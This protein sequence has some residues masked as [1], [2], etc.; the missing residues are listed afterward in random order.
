MIHHEVDGAAMRSAGKAAV[1]VARRAV[2]HAGVMI[3]VER[4]QALVAIDTQTEALGHSLNGEL[5]ELLYSF[6]IHD[7]NN[8]NRT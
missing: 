8:D 1:G 7:F 2:G 3:V 5:A 4:A 6:F